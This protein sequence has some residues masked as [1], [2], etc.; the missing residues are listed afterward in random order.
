MVSLNINWRRRLFASKF[1][2]RGCICEFLLL[3]KRWL[4]S[5]IFSSV[6]IQDGARWQFWSSTHVPS[7]IPFSIIRMAMGPWPWPRDSES[8]LAPPKPCKQLAKC[9]SSSFYGDLHR[10]IISI[11]IPGIGG[12]GVGRKTDKE[13]EE[14]NQEFLMTQSKFHRNLPLQ[15][16]VRSNEVRLDRLN[17]VLTLTKSTVCDLQEGI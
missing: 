4:T 15:L 3:N 10:R 5:Q 16:G 11:I 2:A 6:G 13:N 9:Y 7:L 12:W 1:Y 8:N 17:S 14:W